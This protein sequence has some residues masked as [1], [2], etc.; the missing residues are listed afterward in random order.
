MQLNDTKFTVKNPKSDTSHEVDLSRWDPVGIRYILDYGLKQQNDC[1]SQIKI[2]GKTGAALKEAKDEADKA[3]TERLANLAKGDVPKGGGGGRAIDPELAE[4]AS[5]IYRALGDAVEGTL[6]QFTTRLNK[7]DITRRQAARM[8]AVRHKGKKAGKEVVDTILE[9]TNKAAAKAVAEAKAK[10]EADAKEL[11]DL[12]D[13]DEP[14]IEAG[15]G[16]APVA[17]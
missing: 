12:F 8:V 5:R 15:P 13:V 16:E 10:E 3:L 9:K 14:T 11:A 17:G 1:H 4:F 2:T 6:K 7:G